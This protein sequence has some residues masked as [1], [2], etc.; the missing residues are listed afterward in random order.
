MAKFCVLKNGPALYTECLECEEKELCESKV[1]PKK[2]N[3]KIII[4]G[5]RTFTDYR[6]LRKVLSETAGDIDKSTIEIISGGAKGA[7]RLGE[8]FAERNG[9]KLTVIPAEWDKYG[10]SAGY[11]RNLK[12]AEYAE[13]DGML[14]A[15]WDE[16]SRGT[17]LMIDIAEQKGLW[18]RVISIRQDNYGNDLTIPNI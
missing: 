12:M 15:F 1:K 16:E 7:D 8:L 17:K 9:L 5:T 13:P 10:R 14:I 6:L 4:A 11:K 18:V 2:E 3:V